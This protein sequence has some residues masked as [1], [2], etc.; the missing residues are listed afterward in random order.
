MARKIEMEPVSIETRYGWMEFASKAKAEE[1]RAIICSWEGFTVETA[2]ATVEMAVEYHLAYCKGG[3]AEVYAVIRHHET[4]A[5]IA[6][7]ERELRYH[8][9]SLAPR[10]S[11]LYKSHFCQEH[12]S[13]RW[14]S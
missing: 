12:P 13:Y 9:A 6:R 11:I 3:A 7:A 10:E 8:L 1:F 2:P 5:E 14:G 4:L